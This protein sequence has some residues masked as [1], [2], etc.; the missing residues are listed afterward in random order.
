MPLPKEGQLS[1]QVVG[2]TS[3]TTCRRVSQLQ[4]CQL[5]SS[6][7]Q[8]VY[9]VGLNGCEVPV[10]TSPPEPM[11]KGVNL[12][13]SEPIYL[14][15]DILQ[16]NTEGPELKA[17]PL[18]S[19]S[20]ILTASPV[21]P[22]PPKAEEEVSMTMEVRELLS[23][24]GL[25]TS[26]HAS[27]SSTPKRQEPVVLV[28]S[29]PTKP[30]DFP[31]PVDTSSQVSTSDHA[32]ME[33]TS[34]EEI[35]DP[36]SSTAKAPG[37]SGDAPPPDAAHLWEEANKPLGDL[38]AIKFSTDTHWQR[39]ISE[40]GM[41]LHQNDSETTESINEAK[42]ICT[43]SIQEAEDC[44]SVAIREVEA[45]RAAQAISLQQSHHKTVQHLEE[46]SIKEE[47]KGQLNFLSV[48][49]TALQV[50][51]PEFC[52]TLIA[53]YHVLLGHAPMSHLF[54]IPQGAQPFP[55]G[56]APGLLPLPCPNIHLGPTVGVTLQTQ[57]MPL[58]SAGPHPRQLWRGPLP[59]SCER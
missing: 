3:S 36:S 5:L 19:H 27:G 12:L 58:L 10:I 44:C 29:L 39:L 2:G 28:T 22:P 50:S 55:P 7:S 32:E 1:V 54:S 9:P 57:W 14:K 6:G 13:S 26:E 40:F 23:W 24:A 46:E 21:R 52:S 18:G 41:A 53:S 34:L 15:V 49:Q 47:R 38:L 11:A 45:Q 35:P 33:D 30:V 42:A 8:I 31:K 20:P 25:D 16:S 37:S 43:H 56:S 48:C 4:V 59:Q 51:P 17:L